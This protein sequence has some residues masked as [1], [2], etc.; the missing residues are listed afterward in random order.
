MVIAI[1]GPAG[2]GKSTVAKALA[3]DLGLRFLD[4]GAMYRALAVK[5][6]RAGLGPEDGVAAAVLGQQTEIGFSAGEP[7]RVLLD[8]E[9]VTDAIRTLEIGELASALSAFSEIRRVLVARQQVIVAAGGVVLEGRDATTVI[10]PHAHVKV[11]LT[12]SLEERARR[13]HVEMAAK[14]QA[15]AYGEVRQEVERRDHRDITRQDSPLS[16]AEGATVVETG[17]LSAEEVVNAIRLL[18]DVAVRAG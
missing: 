9:D 12:A 17:G 3:R 7:Q 6:K 14:G 1:D 15:P 4:T 18:A 16:V 10:A 13:R 8:G 2:A 11:Y 5:A